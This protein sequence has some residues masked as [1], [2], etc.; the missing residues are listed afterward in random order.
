MLTPAEYQL[1]AA[2]ALQVAA[3]MAAQRGDPHLYN[4]M[5]DRKSVV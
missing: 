3:E 4:D 1:L 5:A 2:P